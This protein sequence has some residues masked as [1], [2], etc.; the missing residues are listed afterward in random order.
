V[1]QYGNPYKYIL[2]T[3][4]LPPPKKTN[5]NR[6]HTHT[7][8]LTGWES[9]KKCFS[10]NDEGALCLFVLSPEDGRGDE[11]AP[12]AISQLGLAWTLYMYRS[13]RGHMEWGFF[14]FLVFGS[15]P[16][17]DA[18]YFFRYRIIEQGEEHSTYKTGDGGFSAFSLKGS[19]CIH[20]IPL[21]PQTHLSVCAG[22][23]RM[24]A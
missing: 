1:V 9:E 22:S 24:K 18:K 15:S 11:A 4:V 20:L 16:G 10:R 17:V 7:Q 23:V 2:F 12:Q 3:T 8:Y 21:L 6:I 5:P 13:H 19:P 14:F